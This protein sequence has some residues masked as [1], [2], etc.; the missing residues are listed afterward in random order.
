MNILVVSSPGGHFVAATRILA[1]LDVASVHIA[2]HDS[3][4]EELEGAAVYKV[5]HSDRDWRLLIQFFEAAKILIQV[6]PDYVLST[7]ASIAVP[8]FVFARLL[9]IKTIYIETA[10]SVI[11][12]TLTARLVY[13]LSCRFYVR[14]PYLE[15]IFP[16]AILVE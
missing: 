2:I 13:P 11:K 10:S 16:R 3:I 8:F 7:G 1:R 14:Y 15:K 4:V 5:T 9:G 12:P 6:K